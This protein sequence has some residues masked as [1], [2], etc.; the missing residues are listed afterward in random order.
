M[1]LPIYVIANNADWQHDPI[2]SRFL[3]DGA[4]MKQSCKAGAAWVS[5][6]NIGN[7]M[8]KKQFTFV[9]SSVSVAEAWACLEVFK[10]CIQHNILL[11][12]IK[13]IKEGGASNTTFCLVS[14][15]RNA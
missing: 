2:V 3:I 13:E 1:N 14:L 5:L 8:V 15:E 10:W 11:M 4:W 6:D 12:I 7:P 9:A